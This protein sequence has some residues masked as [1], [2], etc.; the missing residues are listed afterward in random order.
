VGAHYDHLGWGGPN[1]NYKGKT[2][3]IHKGAD[4]NASGTAGLLELARI[5]ASNPQKRSLLFVAFS[6]EEEGLFG[7]SYFVNHPPIPLDKISAMINMDMIGRLQN[8][9]LFVIGVGSSSRFEAIVD[10]L[11]AIDSL[12]IGKMESSISASDQTSFYLKN[13]PSIMFFTGAHSDYHKPSDDWEKINYNGES[14]VIGFIQ[15]FIETI[16]NQTQAIDFRKIEGSNGTSPA[17]HNYGM[18]VWF[19]IVPNFENE[20]QGFKIAGTSPGSPAEKAG[21]KENDIIIKIDNYQIKNINDFMYSLREFKAGDTVKVIFLREGK[22]K[23]ALV[24][25]ETKE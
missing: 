8:G 19:G 12:S 16:T 23:E 5:F 17:N 10:S 1:S 14:Y 25:L 9:H 6:G 7:S 4:D 3:M 18:N 24:K 15:K 11:D 21:L 22:Q 13:I 20:P 2:P